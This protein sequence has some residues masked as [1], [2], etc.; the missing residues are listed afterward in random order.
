MATKDH[1]LP[2]NVFYGESLNDQFSNLNLNQNNQNLHAENERLKININNSRKSENYGTA[3]VIKSLDLKINDDESLFVRESSLNKSNNYLSTSFLKLNH[4]SEEHH[5]LKKSKSA[6]NSTLS[7]HIAAYENSTEADSDGR[8]KESSNSKNEKTTVIKKWNNTSKKGH[9]KGLQNPFEFPR[10]QEEDQNKYP[11]VM[12][13]KASQRLRCPNKENLNLNESKNIISSSTVP[14]RPRTGVAQHNLQQQQHSV[15]RENGDLQNRY[16]ISPQNPNMPERSSK[17]KL[18]VFKF[19]VINASINWKSRKRCNAFMKDAKI[20]RRCPEYK[21]RGRKL[22]EI[23]KKNVDFRDNNDHFEPAW[24]EAASF[25][26]NNGIPKSYLRRNAKRFRMSAPYYNQ[27]RNDFIEMLRKNGKE[28]RTKKYTENVQFNFHLESFHGY[29]A[30]DLTSDPGALDSM[31]PSKTLDPFAEESLRSAS[32]QHPPSRSSSRQQNFRPRSRTA[33]PP[34]SSR[35]SSSQQFTVPS[36]SQ[37]QNHHYQQHPRS[38]TLMPPPSLP[39]RSQL[40]R[41]TSSRHQLALPPPPRSQSTRE[42]QSQQPSHSSSRS[43]NFQTSRSATTSERPQS[44]RPT[45]SRQQLALPP[46]PSSERTESFRQFERSSL[47]QQLPPP[48]SSSS[49]RFNSQQ[50]IRSNYRPENITSSSRI[51]SFTQ[52]PSSSRPTSSRPS[53]PPRKFDPPSRQQQQPTKEIVLFEVKSPSARYNGPKISKIS[54]S[55]SSSRRP[56]RSINSNGSSS[57]AEQSSLNQ[58][59][60]ILDNDDENGLLRSFYTKYHMDQICAEEDEKDY[61]SI[62]ELA[63]SDLVEHSMKNP[64]PNG[65]RLREYTKTDYKK[66]R[67]STKKI[68]REWKESLLPGVHDDDAGS[69]YEDDGEQPIETWNRLVR[70][71]KKNNS[72]KRPYNR[73][74]LNEM[75]KDSNN[76]DDIL[77]QSFDSVQ[78]EPPQ[79]TI[80]ETI[81]RTRKIITTPGFKDLRTIGK[82]ITTTTELSGIAEVPITKKH[83]TFEPTTKKPRLRTNAKQQEKTPKISKTQTSFQTPATS[84]NSTIKTPSTIDIFHRITNNSANDSQSPVRRSPRVSGLKAICY[85]V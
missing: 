24:K 30:F 3:A 41:P 84:R 60:S 64:P 6:N 5:K 18:Q 29:D 43:Q 66:M 32:Q 17:R 74:S 13:F 80:E 62:E 31:L 61:K 27:K 77:N 1:C 57:F 44:S 16:H 2:E 22:E 68:L 12:Q 38:R 28:I 58:I 25:S 50:P 81:Q 39:E 71:T 65:L 23:I 35:P 40:S 72:R 75:K 33:F 49:N 9:F 4:E 34:Q 20:A 52:Q 51:N 69:G 79:V 83:P 45:A 82:N 53:H 55:T 46:P 67:S 85:K 73:R 8:K 47:R 11:E 78:S 10:Q 42:R 70:E 76:D 36:Q 56:L 54:T 14:S 21:A 19:S 7:L 15:H 63:N 59:A 48:P 37:S 26:E